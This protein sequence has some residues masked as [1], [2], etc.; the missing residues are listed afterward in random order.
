MTILR[1]LSR[2]GLREAVPLS[3]LFLIALQALLFCQYGHR[4]IDWAY[5]SSFDQATY[6]EASYSLQ[7][8]ALSQ[9][10]LNGVAKF[11]GAGRPNGIMLPIQGMLVQFFFGSNRLA[12]LSLNFGY[13]ALLQVVFFSTARAL[14]GQATF[15]W[16]AV[17]LLL[18]L[19]SAFFWAG[20]L[21]DFRI[22][23]IASC[24]Y[25][26]F[27]CFA[28]RSAGLRRGPWLL[29]MLACAWLLISFRFVT[30]AFLIGFF[31]LLFASFFLLWILRPRNLSTLV[32]DAVPGMKRTFLLAL[33]L[34]ALTSPMIL[35][36]WRAIH[37]YYV[38]GH[39]TGNEKHI[40]AAE[41][42]VVGLSGHLTY[43]LRSLVSDHLGGWFIT[44][45]LGTFA[46]GIVWW[47]RSRRRENTDAAETTLARS[48][49][50]ISLL[51][52]L[53][54]L[55]TPWL[56][57]TVDESKS[58]VIA[59]LFGPP[60]ALLPFVL[61][62]RNHRGPTLGQQVNGLGGLGRVT[63]A[64][65]AVIFG[66][67]QWL[68][69]L[70]AQGSFSKRRASV[71][72]INALYDHLMNRAEQLDL[73]SPVISTD[74]VLD[75]LTSP[76]LNVHTYERSGRWLNARGALGVG[77]FAVSR[78]QA[79]A[80]MNSSDFVLLTD[81][82]KAGVYPFYESMR[83]LQPEMR[84]WCETHLMRDRQF[85]IDG[86]TIT[87]YMR[88]KI[89]IKGL[90]GEWI[91]PEGV[92]LR[93]PIALLDWMRATARS[94]I[95][96]EGDSHV[97]WLRNLPTATARMLEDDETPSPRTGQELPA[98]FE[99]LTPDL[100]RIRLEIKALLAQ[101]NAS[102]GEVIVALRLENASFI[103][104]EIGLNDD[105]RRLVVTQPT[106]VTFE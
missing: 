3:L 75:W 12:L 103:P 105:T 5:P 95:V 42:G 87:V 2:R 78:E 62:A 91:T 64:I 82:P 48:A 53:V 15:G 74:M 11:W 37:D 69:Q 66:C 35:Q 46:V 106:A 77:I 39:L 81:L 29:A 92:R 44:F 83:V 88:P 51:M 40:R 10:L 61:L 58:P 30:F 63:L 86:S 34:V 101:P 41:F 104:K 57:L 60:L 72:Q 94:T 84:A 98:N 19:H 7:R 54:A 9:G 16:L 1:H 52:V 23:F 6:L 71:E 45:W 65:A 93:L 102:G 32:A 59:S 25:G 13:F 47:R 36:N 50:G 90:S 21:F 8:E 67:G 18:S 14:T 43:Y 85:T 89:Q 55:L 27:V 33:T 70:S 4:E 79:L 56:I 73:R 96:F 22:D 31:S 17:G 80:K 38:V 97:V 100:Y 49:W 28:V 99:Q 20:G 76:A 68:T 24:L 26:I